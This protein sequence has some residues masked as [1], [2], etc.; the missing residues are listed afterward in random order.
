MG[1]VLG[2]VDDVRW[3]AFERK[4]EAVER[5]SQRLRASWVHPER[6]GRDAAERLIGKPLEREYALAD[7][8]RRPGVGFDQVAEL[9]AIEKP[10]DAVSRETLRTELGAVTAD[11]VIAQIETSVKYA[12]YIDRQ[13]EQVERLAHFESLQLPDDLD[14]GAVTALGHEVRQKLQ[15]QRPRTLGQASRISGVT[16]AAVSLL[17]VHLRRGRGR[18]E[19]LAADDAAVA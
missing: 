2:L 14:Y 5:E 9:F 8:L 1:R 19:V 18:A 10:A 16:P 4:R 12:G 6:V 7:L 15:A 17:L 11:E 3:A 13:Q